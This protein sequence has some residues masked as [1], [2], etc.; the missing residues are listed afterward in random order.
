[1]ETQLVLFKNGLEVIAQTDVRDDDFVV[2]KNPVR[3]Q[4]APD[5]QGNGVSIQFGPISPILEQKQ[6]IEVDADEILF[7]AR[8]IPEVRNAY[9]GH[10]GSGIITA[11]PDSLTKLQL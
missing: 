9:D 3:C 6:S 11:T 7:I 4:L 2:L 1:M 10:F 8:L 5:A